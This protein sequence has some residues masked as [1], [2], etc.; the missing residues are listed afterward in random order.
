M[1]A[2]VSGGSPV[3]KR[4]GLGSFIEPPPPEEDAAGAC[5]YIHR[6]SE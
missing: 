4:I 1:G 3:T 5:A 2:V 6:E